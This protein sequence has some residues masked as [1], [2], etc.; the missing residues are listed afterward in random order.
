[1]KWTTEGVRAAAIALMWT[2][3]TLVLWL[4]IPEKGEG[5]ELFGMFGILWLVVTFIGGMCGLA[6][7]WDCMWKKAPQVADWLNEK[8]DG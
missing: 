7:L 8:M 1:M 2:C 6:W 5:S 4:N 3:Y